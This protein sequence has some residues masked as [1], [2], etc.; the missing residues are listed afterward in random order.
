MNHLQIE[1]SK[2]VGSIKSHVQDTLKKSTKMIY[3]RNGIQNYVKASFK[4]SLR[5]VFDLVKDML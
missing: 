2:F 5:L 3:L 1:V 4:S